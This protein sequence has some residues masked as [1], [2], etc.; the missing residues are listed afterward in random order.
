MKTTLKIDD[1]SWLYIEK[2]KKNK[3]KV[4]MILSKYDDFKQLTSTQKIL[5]ELL[6]EFNEGFLEKMKLNTTLKIKNF[7]IKNEIEVVDV[8]AC[9]EDNR[10]SKPVIHYPHTFY[11]IAI[12]T[13]KS[14]LST[15]ND[16]IEYEDNEF[17]KANIDM[18]NKA[19]KSKNTSTKNL[20][21]NLLDE[22]DSIYEKMHN[23]TSKKEL[24]K[25]I[26]IISGLKRKIVFNIKNSD[27][28]HW[29]NKK[30][31]AEWLEK[32]RKKT[33]ESYPNIAN[34]YR[35]LEESAA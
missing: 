22:I 17:E 11:D 35:I 29:N 5:N 7:L 3:T 6:E 31:H 32:I 23:E 10:K 4:V 8:I 15:E 24:E 25:E 26:E 30:I 1:L 2:D 21:N 34:I 12:K 13:I 14:Y 28:I 27:Y 19:I 33:I 16:S 9:Y 20:K 18:I